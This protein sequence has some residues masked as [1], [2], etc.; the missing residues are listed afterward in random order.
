MTNKHLILRVG[1]ISICKP[2][3]FVSDSPPLEREINNYK[4]QMKTAGLPLLQKKEVL[5]LIENQIHP[6]IVDLRHERIMD[7]SNYA[8]LSLYKCLTL[9]KR[10]LIRWYKEPFFQNAIRHLYVRMTDGIDHIQEKPLCGFFKVQTVLESENEY[11]ELCDEEN[12]RGSTVCID[13]TRLYFS[14][15]TMIL[16]YH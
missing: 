7:G 15:E 5:N 6:W 14:I 10:L 8:S 16:F 1:H 3:D 9:P 13:F 12:S 2:I 4:E 11:Y